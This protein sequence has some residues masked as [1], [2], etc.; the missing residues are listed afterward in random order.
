[1]FYNKEK[2]DKKIRKGK[3]EKKSTRD[4]NKGLLQRSAT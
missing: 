1:M 2:E 4:S 3:E